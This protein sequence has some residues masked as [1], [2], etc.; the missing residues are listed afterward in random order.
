MT[1]DELIEELV[2]FRRQRPGLGM[3]AVEIEVH[4]AYD[5]GG[6]SIGIVY[7]SDIDT[8]AAVRGAGPIVVIR[9]S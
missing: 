7:A 5:L 3:S 1:L 4:D 8:V 9:T 6:V 2:E